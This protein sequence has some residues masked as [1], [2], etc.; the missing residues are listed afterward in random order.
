VA[1]SDL[2]LVS[3]PVSMPT[4]TNRVLVTYFLFL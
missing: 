4:F 1:R 2:K 3:L